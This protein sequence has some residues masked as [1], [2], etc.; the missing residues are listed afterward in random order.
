MSPVIEKEEKGEKIVSED[1]KRIKDPIFT[2]YPKFRLEYFET[3]ELLF[4]FVRDLDYGKV[5]DKGEICLGFGMVPI[6]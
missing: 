1:L 5:D 6:D 4:D 3:Q 2:R